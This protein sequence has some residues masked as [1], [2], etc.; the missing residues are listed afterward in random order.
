[1]PFGSN[2]IKK[3]ALDAD[4]VIR[5]VDEAIDPAD[6]RLFIAT[7]N[8]AAEIVVKAATS[9]VQ[10]SEQLNALLQ[11]VRAD[12]LVIRIQTKEKP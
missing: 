1:M 4:S 2:E 10:A 12:G 7:M 5:Q 8:K 9:L 3:A 11:Q 6:I